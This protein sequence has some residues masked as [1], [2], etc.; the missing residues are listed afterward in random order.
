LQT[1][2]FQMLLYFALF[3]LISIR[4][5]GPFWSSRPSRVLSVAL[6]ADACVGALIGMRGLADM[7][8]ISLAQTGLII[9]YA[10]ICGL[11]INDP[12]KRI[13][14]GPHR[15]VHPGQQPVPT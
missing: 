5:R 7:K 8:P 14:M 13:M 12:V 4:E 15:P 1:F 11:G 3:S 6:I 10:L 2:A 9:S